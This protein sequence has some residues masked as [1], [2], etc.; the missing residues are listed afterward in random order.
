MGESPK[1]HH[2]KLETQRVFQILAH[3][4]L[5]NFSFFSDALLFL[6]FFLLNSR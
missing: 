5:L 4:Q 3:A 6:A 1:Y 2:A